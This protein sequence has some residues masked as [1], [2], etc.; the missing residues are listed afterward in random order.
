MIVVS[1]S[2]NDTAWNRNDD[3]CDGPSTDN[4]DWSKFNVTCAAAAAEIFRP[5]FESLFAQIMALRG[6]KPTIFQTINVYNDWIGV[7]GGVSSP[8]EM[9]ATRVVVDAWNEMV[10]KAA[11]A[12]GFTCAD[13]YH[14]FN[15]ADGL[16]SAVELL[17]SDTIHPS[18]KGNEVIAQV[19][20]EL[21]FAPLVP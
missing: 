10:C 5:K 7:P 13:I 4:I 16:Q 1:I 20:T 15:G 2:H 9:E 18:D 17:A 14:A 3:P 21:G 6:G 19:L 8:T 12:N 11:Q